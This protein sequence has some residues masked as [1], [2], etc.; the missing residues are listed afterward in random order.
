MAVSSNRLAVQVAKRAGVSKTISVARRLGVASPMRADL[1]IALGSSEISLLDLTTCY[2]PFAN[3]GK[4]VCAHGI[5]E[6]NDSEGN[7]LYRRSGSGIGQV[8]AENHVRQMN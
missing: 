6:I 2:V 7:L 1:S 8:V 5:D 3:V 4:G